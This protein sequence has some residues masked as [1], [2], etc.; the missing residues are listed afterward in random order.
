MLNRLYPLD[1]LLKHEATHF[2]SSCVRLQPGR[3]KPLLLLLRS[4]SG[5]TSESALGK[6]DI[7][8]L[9]TQDNMS[10]EDPGGGF[11]SRSA[12]KR[13]AAPAGCWVLCGMTR[14]ESG[15]GCMRV[16]DEEG[17]SAGEKGQKDVNTGGVESVR[18]AGERKRSGVRKKVGI[19]WRTL[20]VAEVEV[21]CPGKSAAFLHPFSIFIRHSTLHTFS[22]RIATPVVL[23]FFRPSSSSSGPPT[24]LRRYAPRSSAAEQ[25]LQ[26]RRLFPTSSD[27]DSFFLFS[28]LVDFIS[29]CSRPLAP[30]RF[31]RRLFPTS[32]FSAL[33]DLLRRQ[34]TD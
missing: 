25:L 14:E 4:S 21:G 32:G 26:R 12:E 7:A 34:P 20:D 16:N 11:E 8:N 24:L 1:E 27:A 28:T 9:A 23:Q 5:S 31:R 15:V 17:D 18:L 2:R 6:K 19:V 22:S 30:L 33:R 13:V 29:S 10:G 3:S